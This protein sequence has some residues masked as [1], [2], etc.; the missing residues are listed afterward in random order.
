M[1][2]GRIRE[3]FAQGLITLRRRRALGI[4]VLSARFT[5]HTLLVSGAIGP[6]T[7][8]SGRMRGQSRSGLFHLLRFLTRRF[9][10]LPVLRRFVE[11][12]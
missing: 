1:I 11:S 7:H 3:L 2:P 6:G 9:Q 4:C 10:G 8:G 5:L 12:G